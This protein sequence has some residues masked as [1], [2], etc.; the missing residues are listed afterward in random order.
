MDEERKTIETT[1]V[2]DCGLVMF[3]RDDYDTGGSDSG[4][5]CPDCG[6]ESFLTVKQILAVISPRDIIIKD[7]AMLVRRLCNGADIHSKAMDYFD[8]KNLTGNILR[9]QALRQKGGE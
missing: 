3:D 7:L 6:S 5:C 4:I 2:C 8:R 9:D 1:C